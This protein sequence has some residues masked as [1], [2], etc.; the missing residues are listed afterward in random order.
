[1]EPTT[2]PPT[3]TAFIGLGANLGN[4]Q[5]TLH[6]A[7]GVIAHLPGV[8][9]LRSSRLYSSAPIDAPGPFYVNA[10]ASIETSLTA[11][12]LLKALQNI[13]T[14]FGRER[15]YQNAPRTLDLDLLLYDEATINEPTLVVPHPR[16]HLR[17]FVLRPLAELVDLDRVVAGQPIQQWLAECQAQDCSPLN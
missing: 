4:P 5:E 9:N 16:M 14:A 6:Q 15:P 1:M 13:E 10:A 8:S 11:L 7:M 3:T 2:H 17:A 12:E